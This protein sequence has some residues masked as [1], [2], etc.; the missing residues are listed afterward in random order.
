M[1]RVLLKALLEH[2][3]CEGERQESVCRRKILKKKRFSELFESVLRVK[4]CH[5]S[6]DRLCFIAHGAVEMVKEI[7]MDLFSLICLLFGILWLF[8]RHLVTDA[9]RTHGSASACTLSQDK[10]AFVDLV[11]KSSQTEPLLFSWRL[12]S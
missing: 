5:L 8:R 6:P 11:S 7:F 12:R 9:R 3:P 10:S 1:K 4:E 2:G